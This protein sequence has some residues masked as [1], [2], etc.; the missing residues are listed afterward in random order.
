MQQAAAF[1]YAPQASSDRLASY[2]RTALGDWQMA[3]RVDREDPWLRFV[4]LAPDRPVVIDVAVLVDGKPYSDAREAWIDDVLQPKPQRIQDVA[5]QAVEAATGVT[6]KTAKTVKTIVPAA[7]DDAKVEAEYRAAPTMRKRVEDYVAMSGAATDR[8]EI[9]W[10]IAEWGFGPPV[11][12]LDQSLSW[13]RAAVEPLL[14]LLDTNRSGALEAAEIAAVES[15][16]QKADGNGDDIVDVRELERKASGPAVLPYS[17]DHPLVVM[18]DDATDLDSLSATCA[19]L[20]GLTAAKLDELLSGPAEV[21]LRIQFA[22]GEGNVDAVA[23]YANGKA[24]ASFPF[25]VTLDLGATSIEFSAAAVANGKDVANAAATQIAV[26]ATIEGNPLL[27][28]AD[29]DGSG[30]LTLRE[31]QQ[32]TGLLASLDHNSDGQVAAAELPVPIR[33]AVTLGP[34]VHRLLEQES[35]ATRP[36]RAAAGADEKSPPAIAPDWFRSMDSNADGDLA[37]SEFLGTAEQFAQFDADGDGLL[38][39]EEATKMTPA[40]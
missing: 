32:L 21:S 16:L 39:L 35:R 25:A 7:T 27:R 18:I 40:D 5:V 29:K 3:S 11:V 33:F 12:L 17:A 34:Q 14:A 23:I 9:R 30:R 28:L 10:L 8:A 36:I 26:G 22:G 4:L 1:N 37:R 6:E 20:Y 13:Q 15:V 31:R 2:Q 24:V 19:R 38:S